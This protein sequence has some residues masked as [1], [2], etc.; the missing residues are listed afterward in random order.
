M[1][2]PHVSKKCLLSFHYSKHLKPIIVIF[3]KQC[4]ESIASKCM[5]NFPPHLV[6]VATL[7][8]NT[9]AGEY[10]RCFHL[11]GW[12]WKWSDQLATDKFQYSLKIHDWHVHV[13]HHSWLNVRSSTSRHS[14]QYTQFMVRH[15]QLNRCLKILAASEDFIHSNSELELLW[16]TSTQCIL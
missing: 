7:P 13:G 8:E 11:G 10:A 5:H 1:N 3:G 9:L 15:C 4:P 16:A 6:C 2:V 14:R 12:L